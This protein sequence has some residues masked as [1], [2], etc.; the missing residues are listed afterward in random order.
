MVFNIYL[1]TVMFVLGGLALLI[2]GIVNQDGTQMLTGAV[3]FLPSAILAGYLAWG[4][5]SG[6][7]V[8][9]TAKHRRRSP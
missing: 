2:A 8:L 9:E 3:L 4:W 1:G 7:R 5:R 6:R